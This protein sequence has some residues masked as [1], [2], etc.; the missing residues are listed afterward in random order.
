MIPPIM[1]AKTPIEAGNPLALAMPRLKGS[2][3]KN[4]KNPETI[5]VFQTDLKSNLEVVCIVFIWCL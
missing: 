5:S 2:A 4:T 1:A 3:N